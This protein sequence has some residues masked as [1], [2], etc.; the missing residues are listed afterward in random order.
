MCILGFS[1]SDFGHCSKNVFQVGTGETSEPV[2]CRL[3][4]GL[5]KR[6]Q[7][8]YF[9]LVLGQSNKENESKEGSASTDA[10]LS[11]DAKQRL[12][13]DAAQQANALTG[14]NSHADAHNGATKCVHT[15]LCDWGVP[16]QSL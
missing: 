7:L 16:L 14:S 3:E 1:R 15:P 13:G 8:R 10:N 12:F 2:Q 11:D 5:T 4:A 6:V 9:A